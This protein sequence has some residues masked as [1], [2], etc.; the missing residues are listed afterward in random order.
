MF[1]VSIT[2]SSLAIVRAADALLSSFPSVWGKYQ[3][4]KTTLEAVL[5]Q[6]QSLNC[7]TT[8]LSQNVLSGFINEK[9]DDDLSVVLD[10]SLKACAT[11]LRDLQNQVEFVQDANGKTTEYMKN[12]HTWK[13]K[14]FVAL[15]ERLRLQIDVLN[16]VLDIIQRAIPGHVEQE[17]NTDANDSVLQKAEDD[18]STYINADDLG[19]FV[20]ADL[21]SLAEATIGSSCGAEL[22]IG[23]LKGHTAEIITVL[24]SPDGSKIASGSVDGTLRLW[25]AY[26][27]A[28]LYRFQTQTPA[29]DM[30][31][32]FSR[33]SRLLISRP[34]ARV[35]PRNEITISIWDTTSGLKVLTIVPGY[36]N[37]AFSLDGK[38]ATSLD[39]YDGERT[40]INIYTPG[41]E[42]CQERSTLEKAWSI[43]SL[44]FSDDGTLLA[45]DYSGST[46]SGRSLKQFRVWSIR[47]RKKWASI[48]KIP[49]RSGEEY[50]NYDLLFSPDSQRIASYSWR[51][52]ILV[53]DIE[54]GKQIYSFTDDAITIRTMR[55]LP[56]GEHVFLQLWLRGPFGNLKIL[57]L[58]SGQILHSFEEV[59]CSALSPD[60]KRLVYE[61]S[62][63]QY[64]V[65][66]TS[67][68]KLH[69]LERQ[70][71]EEFPNKVLVVS[72][73]WRQLASI[74]RPGDATQS[75]GIDIASLYSGVKAEQ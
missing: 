60:G 35:R 48:L 25:N 12:K 58:A 57:D 55:F 45:A 37:T 2:T 62:C 7:A 4:A 69:I 31:L 68:E 44:V 3:F 18:A 32:K 53:W 64:V 28:C 66:A 49:Y 24:F 40:S 11:L 26:T 21:E 6:L 17:L 52:Q 59:L 22:F 71:F 72:P 65:D 46:W 74:T 13:Q 36:A 27:G 42:E 41:E 10:D 63:H 14:D 16:L 39:N 15:G 5:A 38:I 19:F 73:H 43:S 9:E 54:T 67:G 51:G 33:N 29:E 56:D 30:E 50:R 1:Y 75:H 23:T 34:T 47:D 20:R 70:D 8:E 61:D